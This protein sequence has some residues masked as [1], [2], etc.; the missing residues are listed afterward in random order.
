MWHYESKERGHTVIATGSIRKESSSCFSCSLLAHF[1]CTFSLKKSLKKE[2]RKISIGALFSFAGWK[3]GVEVSI[4]LV[5]S[6]Y[7]PSLWI[8]F[9]KLRQIDSKGMITWHKLNMP[10][11]VNTIPRNKCS[12]RKIFSKNKAFWKLRPDLKSVVQRSSVFE[13]ALLVSAY[14]DTTPEAIRITSWR[15]NTLPCILHIR[16]CHYAE[17]QSFFS[18]QTVSF[19]EKCQKQKSK[20]K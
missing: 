16:V 19:Q 10:K 5:T 2:C 9:R 17:S 20:I 7:F 18:R 14:Q 13:T 1:S 3:E 12:F 8:T 6:Q 15:L 4:S 11:W